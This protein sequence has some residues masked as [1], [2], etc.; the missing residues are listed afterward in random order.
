M[1]RVLIVDDDP[2]TLE[3]LRLLLQQHGY[4]ILTARDGCEAVEILETQPVDLILADVAMPRLNGYQLCQ[5][6]KNSAEPNL[7][8]IPLVFVSARALA[9]DIRYAKSLGADDY[10][11]KPFNIEDLLAVIKGK[12]RAAELLHQTF[13]QSL[14]DEPAEATTL[15]IGNRQLQLDHGQQQAWLDGEKL[16]LTLKEMRLLEYLARR[17]GWVVS[18][19]ELV[20]ATHGLEQVSKHQARRKSVRSIVAYLRRKLADPLDGAACIQT[21]RGR[22]YML[23]VQ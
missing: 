1:K 21:V 11:T 3:F 16:T 5:L 22:G 17:P 15:T 14:F 12:L 23:V 2:D 19:V 8:M 18:D 6:V 4:E 10:L 13:T 9:S 7:A 20:K